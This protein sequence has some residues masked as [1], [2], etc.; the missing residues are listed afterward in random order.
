MQINKYLLMQFV[1]FLSFVMAFTSPVSLNAFQTT[2]KDLANNSQTYLL[3]ETQDTF[4]KVNIEKEISLDL[5]KASMSEALKAV[6]RETGLKL[7][8]QGIFE[9]D[10]NIT[11][12]NKKISVGKALSII[13]EGTNFDYKVSQEGYLLIHEVVKGNMEV[14]F[15]TVS[16]TVTDASSGETLPGVNVV[17]KGT[18]TGTSTNSEGQYELDVPSLQDTLMFSFIGY[19]TQ[20]IP[21]N[22][23][24]QI[25]VELQSQA[26]T[27]E[28]VVVI[29]FGTQQQGSVSGSV[30]PIEGRELF[31]QPSI[32]TSAALQGKIPGVQVI[33]N[34][35]QPGNNEGTIRIRGTGTLGNADPLVLI[36]GVEGN[37]NDIPSSDIENISV[38]K[39]ASAAAI[40]G[41]RASNGVILVTTKRGQRGEMQMSYSS[42]VGWQEATNTPDAVDAGT[43][44]RLE[45]IGATNLGKEPIWSQEFIQAWEDNHKT[46]PDQF[47]NTDW[48]DETFSKAGV[49]YRQQLDISGGSDVARY[50]GS[51]QYDEQN[52]EIPNNQFQRFNIRLNTD[53]TVSDKLDFVADVNALRTDQR[54][55]AAGLELVT[56]QAFR[57]PQI[58]DARFN[59]GD[60]AAGRDGTNPVANAEVSGFN[61]IETNIFRGRFGIDYKPTDN[62]EFK[63]TYF[64]EFEKTFVEDFSQQ[65]I[66][67]E[68]ETGQVV[69]VSRLRDE[70]TNSFN[71]TFTN[72][73][74]ATLSYRLNLTDHSLEVL[75]GYEYIQV[76]NDFFSAFRDDFPLQ[77]FSVLDAASQA[78][79]E[80]SGNATRNTLLSSFQRITYDYDEKYLADF[81]IRVDGSSRF[82]KSNRW[83][84]F[85]SFSLGW[86]VAEESFMDSFDFLN[87]LKLR[88]SWGRIGNQNVTGNDFPF[89]SVVDLNQNFV[90][91]GQVQTGAALT[92]FNNPN[93]QWEVATTKNIG[94]DL[95]I[96]ANRVNVT[97]EYFERT[98][99]DI[100]LQ[101]PIP[102]VNGLAPPF[103]N[104]GEVEN[105]GW[106]ISMGY[107]DIVELFNDDFQFDV[108]F[109]ISEV[110][111]EVTDLR[112]AGPFIN[113]SN[114]SIIQVGDP[115][116]AIFGLESDGLF[117]SQ[118]AIENSPSQ[119]R[120]VAPGDI[121]FVDQN[122]DGV[123]NQD[124]RKVIGDPFPDLNYG[125]NL[126]AN[127]KSFDM[128]LFLQGVGSR[129]VLLQQDAVWALF[130]AG[131]VKKWQAEQFWRPEKPDNDFPR[132]TQTT[133]HNNFRATDFWVSNG[134]F[135]RLRN[136]Q[137]GYTLP[138]Q[139]TNNLNLSQVRMYF[140][141]QNLATWFN[142]MPP[143]VDPNTP[144][145]TNGT[146]FPITKLFAFGIDVNL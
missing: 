54:E 95:A 80:N 135:L 88:G 78:N 64:P 5:K 37:L 16:G 129:D 9:S 11:I 90:L 106:E 33:Q 121:K 63:F 39:D 133:D 89:A 36:D 10:K 51:L 28:D 47:P 123:I 93:L 8:Y 111:N 18:T 100:L 87:Q 15:Q 125:I 114:N 19:Q 61:E 72:N 103:Q 105:T 92:D 77:G 97:F 4:Y 75:S 84:V 115:I 110:D 69:G 104:A 14:F 108:S 40:Y 62:I 30:S 35:G 56:R 76:K 32:Q 136:L 116:N 131:T 102:L 50:R 144:N 124:D 82:A 21:I 45:N 119:F 143:G 138:Q 146:F 60:L 81:T 48:V 141:G 67:R 41:N 6:S 44:M 98:T 58:F 79:D 117:Q 22:G 132:L 38:L 3:S 83:G 43:H 145:N 142:K 52:A 31:E 120:Q 86:N 73:A 134:K 122:G 23:R 68:P 107:T 42:L 96:L 85:P 24:S 130:N 113:N 7:T 66:A 128:S 94:M 137:F 70:L 57:L 112:G 65:F 126:S 2:G 118:Q 1:V 46:M 101:L 139:W 20:Q 127:Y 13:L 29:G 53:V 17:L 74:N 49:Q 34:S 55:P 26:V 91:G 25:D 12:K 71:R 109:N 99:D 59:N 27:G 140:L